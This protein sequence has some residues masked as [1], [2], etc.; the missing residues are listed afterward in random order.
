MKLLKDIPVHSFGFSIYP[1][2]ALLSANLI[3]VEFGV[4]LRPAFLSIL[5]TSV[6]LGL[7]WVA[8]R[9]LRKAGMVTTVLLLLFFTYGHVYQFIE[10][11]ELFG[12]I[13]GRHRYL[14]PF[15]LVIGII[16]LWLILKQVK[17]FSDATQVFNLISFILILFPIVQIINFEVRLTAGERAAQAL[18]TS[19]PMLDSKPSEN[20]PDVYYIVLDTYTRGDALLRDFN[21]DNSEFLTELQEIGFYVADCS[22]SNYSYTQGS[23]TAAL[24]LE[25]IPELRDDL[26]ELGLGMEDIWVLL[27]QSLVRREL[28]EIGYKTVAFDTGYEWS[29]LRDSDYYF[30][31][32]STPFSL[33]VVTPFESLLLKSTAVLIFTDFQSKIFVDQLK[34]I[35]FPHAEYV[36]AQLFILD[37]LA[38]IP[39]IPD[40]TLTFAHVLIPHPPYVFDPEGKIREESAFF[41]GE[42]SSPIDEQYLVEGYTGEIQFINMRVL[43]IVEQLLENSDPAPIIIIQGDHGL[44]DENRLQILNAYY[45]PDGG[46]EV[47]YPS[48]SPVN[49]FRIFFDYYFGTDHGLLPDESF[50]GDDF[51]NPVAESSP[52]CVLKPTKN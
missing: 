42:D 51:E 32:G 23:I 18:E 34:A 26:K 45:F 46:N 8:L 37:Q 9:D 7:L 16:S 29:Q 19:M 1:I 25:Y 6:L 3:E 22:R 30:G 52:A 31:V 20:L 43:E 41:E 12:V 2:L 44:R 4:V 49:S 28:E 38:T 24:N 35:N 17:N 10:L 50:L 11:E 47:L 5:A 40:P 48:L 21:F 33:D 14:I 27:K 36:Q 15:Y 39:R 13:I